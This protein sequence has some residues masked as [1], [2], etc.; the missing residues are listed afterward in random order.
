MNPIRSLDS[1]RAKRAV[2]VI[3]YFR[4]LHGVSGKG[5]EFPPYRVTASGAWAASRPAHLYCFFKKLNLSKCGLFIDLG[6][7]DGVAS[8]IAGL[9]TR[10]VGIESDPILV[11]RS[12]RTV[13]ELGLEDRVRFIRAD[14]LT[15]HI[16]RADCLYIYPDRPV[17]FLEEALKGWIGTLLIYGPHFP[18]ER[19]RLQKKLR[20]G[21]ESISVYVNSSS[22]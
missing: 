12:L 5:G 3:R 13:R 17:N 9:F 19:L 20:C 2:D 4:Q 22:R 10:S 16:R 7:G 8:C 18:L 21:K 11:S 15:Q 6:S 14:F 1:S